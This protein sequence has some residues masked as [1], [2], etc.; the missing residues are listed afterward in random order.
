MSTQWRGKE[1]TK[2]MH[3]AGMAELA[4]Q[5]EYLKAEAVKQ[6]PVDTGILAGSA[7]V[8]RKSDAFEVSFNTPYALRRH[9]EGPSRSG[10]TTVTKRAATGKAKY[11]EDPLNARAPKA[12]KAIADAIKGAMR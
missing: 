12:I 3:R 4:K 5:A 7:T 10:V 8:T 1:L 2:A 11:L 9:E 6:T